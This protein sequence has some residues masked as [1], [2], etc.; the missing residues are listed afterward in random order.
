MG[1]GDILQAAI[2]LRTMPDEFGVRFYKM[3]LDSSGT[4][5]KVCP[6]EKS[7]KRQV[8]SGNRI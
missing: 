4:A 2:W 3:V 5:T 6:H 8:N 7:M 1:S